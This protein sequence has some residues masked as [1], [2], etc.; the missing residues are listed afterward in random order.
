M[1]DCTKL[2]LKTLAEDKLYATLI[3][4]FFLIFEWYKM[5]W[6]KGEDVGYQHV[7]RFPQ[8]FQDVSFPGS[9]NPVIV[10]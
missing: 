10:L 7:L 4:I 2:K 9:W 8:C 1:F 5:L 3:V 6:G